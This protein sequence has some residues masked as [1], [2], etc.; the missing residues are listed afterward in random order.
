L[1]KDILAIP[2]T[3]FVLSSD[4]GKSRPRGRERTHKMIP[5]IVIPQRKAKVEQTERKRM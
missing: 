3:G 1:L 5:N 4:T 2:L